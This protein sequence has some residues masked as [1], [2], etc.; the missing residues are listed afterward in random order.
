MPVS[1]NSCVAEFLD[2]NTGISWTLPI[3]Y[4]LIYNNYG[5]TQNTSTNTRK[6]YLQSIRTNCSS[7][8]FHSIFYFQNCSTSSNFEHTRARHKLQLPRQRTN[9]GTG[10]VHYLYVEG[11]LHTRP[12]NAFDSTLPRPQKTKYSWWMYLQCTISA[13]R[14]NN[15]LKRM[16]TFMAT[17]NQIHALN[18]SK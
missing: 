9:A 11:W 2:E 15:I 10:Q 4:T 16:A 8:W 7:S 5:K 13:E 14:T 3:L 12:A 1:S 17:F 18:N 6:N